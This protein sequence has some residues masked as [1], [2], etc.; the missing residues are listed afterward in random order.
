MVNIDQAHR[1]PKTLPLSEEVELEIFGHELRAEVQFLFDG[2]SY[3][4]VSLKVL[5]EKGLPGFN[6]TPMIHVFEETVIKALRELREK[7]LKDNDDE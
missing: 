7:F 2:E 6:L 4:V 3:D 5:S 1:E